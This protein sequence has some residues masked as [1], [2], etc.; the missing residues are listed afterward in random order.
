MQ[1]FM[2]ELV[3]VAQWDFRLWKVV[4]KNARTGQTK[5][6]WCVSTEDHLHDEC[7]RRWPSEFYSEYMEYDMGAAQR[8]PQVGTLHGHRVDEDPWTYGQRLHEQKGG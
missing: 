3:P 7:Q 4:W 5:E 1:E 2:T 8:P 6:L